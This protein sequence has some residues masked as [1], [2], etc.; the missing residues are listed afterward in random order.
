MDDAFKAILDSL[1]PKPARSKLEP[2]TELIQELRKRDRS[3]QE[4]ADILR[5]RCGISVGT[6]TV[7]NFV[8]VRA[9]ARKKARSARLAVESLPVPETSATAE[10]SSPDAVKDDVVWQR[11]QALKQRFAS[12]EGTGKKEFEYN[13]NEPLQLVSDPRTKQ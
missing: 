2:F 11:I 13:E 12:R 1:P 7:Y 4:I 8:R 5:D 3:Y 9:A 10:T 6:H